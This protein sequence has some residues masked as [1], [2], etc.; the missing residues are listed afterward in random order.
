MAHVSN[1]LIR[2]R[3]FMKEIRKRVEVIQKTQKSHHL[4]CVFP[5]NIDTLEAKKGRYPTPY[6]YVRTES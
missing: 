3:F 6:L 2:Q 1:N 4:V 5:C